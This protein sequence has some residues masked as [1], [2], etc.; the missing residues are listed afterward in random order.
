M[1]EITERHAARAILLTPDAEVLLLRV[2]VAN[3]RFW[4]APGGGLRPGEDASQAL[5]RELAEEVGL[6]HAAIGPLL[7]RGQRLATLNGR[8]WRQHEQVFLVPVP[9][10]VPVIRDRAEARLQREWRWWQRDEIRLTRERLVPESLARILRDL[11]D[12][13][14]PGTPPPIE[15]IEE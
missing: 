6:D 4:I 1:P 14:P 10:F 12:Q 13:G 8:R 5:R 2:E 9:R 7:W 15:V 11:R 3:G